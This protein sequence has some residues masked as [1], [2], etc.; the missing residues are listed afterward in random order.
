MASAALVTQPVAAAS[1]HFLMP[2]LCLERCGGNATTIAFDLHQIAA[3]SSVIN[4]AAFE[5][6]NLGPNGTLVVNNLTQVVDV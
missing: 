5:L 6:F 3:K 2:W 1:P 4:A